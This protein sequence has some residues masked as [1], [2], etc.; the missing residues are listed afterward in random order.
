MCLQ[1]GGFLLPREPLLELRRSPHAD[2]PAQPHL[3]SALIPGQAQLRDGRTAY[4]RRPLAS[5]TADQTKAQRGHVIGPKS[6]SKWEAEKQDPAL[7]A[8]NVSVFSRCPKPADSAPIKLELRA[9]VSRQLCAQVRHIHVGRRGHGGGRPFLPPR[10]GGAA[11]PAPP[12]ERGGSKLHILSLDWAGFGHS[13]LPRAEAAV[14]W[15]QRRGCGKERAL[16]RGSGRPS[17]WCSSA[18]SSPG[19]SLHRPHPHSPSYSF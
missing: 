2:K 4:D 5:F 14:P 18:G 3:G 6:H 10:P 8:A 12:A 16:D 17:F 9:Y 7:P 15:K 19:T 1:E 11:P 13:L